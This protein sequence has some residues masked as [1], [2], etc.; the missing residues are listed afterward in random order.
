M[1]KIANK[2]QALQDIIYRRYTLGQ[3]MYTISM[4]LVDQYDIS[5]TRSYELIRE[6]KEEVGTAHSELDQNVLEDAVEILEGM[7]EKALTQGN[8]KLALSV[9]QEINKLHQLYIQKLDITSDGEK[10][11]I[12]INTKNDD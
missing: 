4:W 10:I 1:A 12:N 7:R 11:T 5:R 8:D 9:Q 3:S 6:A 2:P